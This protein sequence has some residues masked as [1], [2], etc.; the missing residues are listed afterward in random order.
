MLFDREWWA[1]KYLKRIERYE[2]KQA[3]LKIHNKLLTKWIAQDKKLMAEHT[4]DMTN[5]EYLLWAFSTGYISQQDINQ[6]KLK[7]RK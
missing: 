4:Q 5:D 3:E 7:V 1:T 6:E 2:K